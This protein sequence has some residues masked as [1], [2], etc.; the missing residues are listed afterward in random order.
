M[1]LFLICQFVRIVNRFSV[2][3]LKDKKKRWI[4]GILTTCCFQPWIRRIKYHY[5][6]RIPCEMPSVNTNFISNK[7]KAKAFPFSATMESDILLELPHFCLSANEIVI[8][9]SS[10]KRKSKDIAIASENLLQSTI[11]PD[12]INCKLFTRNLRIMYQQLFLKFG[13]S[14]KMEIILLKSTL[15]LVSFHFNYNFIVFELNF[16]IVL[17]LNS[18]FLVYLASN[19][20]SI[21]HLGTSTGRVD[22]RIQVKTQSG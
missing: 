21:A 8:I 12:T 10:I 11:E 18:W 1:A 3:S 17:L 5:N 19:A 15:L 20:E 9:G 4:C 7:N 16:V 6:P 13:P 14:K 22:A 2:Q